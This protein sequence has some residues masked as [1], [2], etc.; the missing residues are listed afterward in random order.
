MTG[1][2]IPTATLETLERGEEIAIVYRND[3]DDVREVRIKKND[4]KKQL[5]TWEDAGISMVWGDIPYNKVRKIT[6]RYRKNRESKSNA[7]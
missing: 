1:Q 7:N 6:Q 5:I 3:E 4:R 2:T